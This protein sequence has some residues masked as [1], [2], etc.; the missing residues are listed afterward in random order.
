MESLLYMQRVQSSALRDITHT[1]LLS[2][3]KS[4]VYDRPDS[5]LSGTEVTA[6]ILP[7]SIY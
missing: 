1:L 7:S 5:S 6:P 2:N 4:Q 3:K